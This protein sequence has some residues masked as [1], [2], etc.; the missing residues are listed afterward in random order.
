[1]N[2]QITKQSAANGNRDERIQV[3][4]TKGDNSNEITKTEALGW[5]ILRFSTNIS[6][7]LISLSLLPNKIR[8]YS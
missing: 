1:M 7:Y 8:I 4:H 3:S 2:E 5:K 6:S